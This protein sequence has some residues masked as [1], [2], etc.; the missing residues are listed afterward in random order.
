[1]VIRLV[2]ANTIMSNLPSLKLKNQLIIKPKTAMV[3]PPTNSRF[4]AK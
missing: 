1:M 2:I 4:H 3:E